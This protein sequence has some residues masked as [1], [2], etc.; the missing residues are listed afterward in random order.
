MNRIQEQ[1]IKAFASCFDLSDDLK[2]A[3]LLITGATGLIGSTLIHCL[4]ALG[5]GVKIIAPL[6]NTSKCKSL[7]SDEELAAINVIE[8]SLETID[9]TSL[10]KMD[11]IVHCAAPTSSKFFVEHAIETFEIIY[12]GT[13]R[14]LKYAKENPVK[15]F[16]YLSSLE[17][18]GTQT[19]DTIPVTENC[20]FYLN[21]LSIR[22][23]YPMAKRA[24]EHL[25]HLYASQYGVA[26]KIARLTQTTGAGI[27]KDDNRVIAQF[28]RLASQG[29]DI[30]LHTTG[31][32]ARPYCYTT[33]AVAGILYILLKGEP[34]EAYNVS[35]DE[36]Y[37]SARGMAE[38]IRDNFNPNISVR[39]EINENMGYAPSSKLK[40]TSAKLV[41]LG[42]MPK[43]GLKEIFER[44]IA[45]LND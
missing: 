34:G 31:K 14:L 28:A 44:L 38:Y 40:L 21:P 13:E 11:Y 42:W 26:A 1:D 30:V 17:V 4:L 5:K 6:R 19:D 32:A 7:F 33:D 43:Y 25:C 10:G 39:V 16:V 36:T 20:Q 2:D 12:N 27:A 23:S 22:S 18:Y 3:S 9:Y 8:C 29:Q 15:G 24:T 35:N 37:I 41:S 45:Y